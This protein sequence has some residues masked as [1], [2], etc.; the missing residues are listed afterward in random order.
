M[1]TLRTSALIQSNVESHWKILSN[2][3]D[4]LWLCSKTVI[5]ADTFRIHSREWKMRVDRLGKCFNNPDKWWQW[6]RTEWEEKKWY[7]VVRFW[8]YCKGYNICCWFRFGECEIEES[9]MSSRLW[10]QTPRKME[11]ELLSW[12]RLRE[13]QVWARWYN[14]Y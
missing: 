10:S 13:D 1:T 2:D 4:I 11:K 14:I 12:R 9:K 8:K 5:Q 3:R 6:L 7:K